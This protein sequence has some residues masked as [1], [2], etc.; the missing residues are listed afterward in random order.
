MT[1]FS[2]DAD[3]N[4]IADTIAKELFS[5]PVFQMRAE[6]RRQYS[7]ERIY[8]QKIAPLLVE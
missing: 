2:A 3:P 5:N 8:T 1:Y 6:V 7:W 4:G